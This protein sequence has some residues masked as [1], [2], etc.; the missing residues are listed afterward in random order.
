MEK[1]E[2]DRIRR[3]AERV[4]E[5]TGA[6]VSVKLTTAESKR[7]LLYLSITKGMTEIPNF[8]ILNDK[9]GER[10]ATYLDGVY[11]GLLFFGN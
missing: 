9:I 10:I 6:T 7:K 1:F 8:F 2:K 3:A 4:V 11:E 5:V